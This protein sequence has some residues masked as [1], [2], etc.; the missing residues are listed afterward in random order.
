MCE[1]TYGKLATYTAGIF[2]KMQREFPNATFSQLD[3]A[4]YGLYSRRICAPV[5][6]QSM[7]EHEGDKEAVLLEMAGLI[8]MMYG[9]KWKRLEELLEKEYDPLESTR[10]EYT[11]EGT[12]KHEGESSQLDEKG[13]YGFDSAEPS[14]DTRNNNKTDSKAEDETTSHYVRK[15]H[16]NGITPQQLFNSEWELRQRN[17]IRE[18]FR[19]VADFLTLQI[20]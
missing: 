8:L 10:E 16:N 17:Y 2:S 11:S 15:G 14:G 19:D 4:F 20:Y 12:L 13:I 3:M 1:L 7:K 5:V 9:D 18:V 6:E